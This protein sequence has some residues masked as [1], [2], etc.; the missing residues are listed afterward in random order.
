MIKKALLTH[1]NRQDEF[2]QAR[3]LL[4]KS[5][6]VYGI[7][8]CSDLNYIK[9]VVAVVVVYK[10]NNNSNIGQFEYD[11][12]IYNNKVVVMVVKIK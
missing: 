5:C 7:V 10:Y 11:F 6:E 2:F 9:K 3:L 12:K 8:G 4:D 1:R